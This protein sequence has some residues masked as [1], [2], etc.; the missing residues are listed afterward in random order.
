[1]TKPDAK[2]ICHCIESRI[3][4][5]T[6][7][8]ATEFASVSL[9]LQYVV[10]L[11][12]NNAKQWHA[13]DMARV[14]NITDA[15]VGQQKRIIDKLN[16]RRVDLINR[17]HSAFSELLLPPGVADVPVAFTSP[18][19]LID[20]LSILYLRSH[21]LRRALS[22]GSD[23]A[24]LLNSVNECMANIG[25]EQQHLEWLLASL[26]SGSLKLFHRHIAK[27]YQGD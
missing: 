4:A 15:Q 21:M 7:G 27:V 22:K 12:D 25:H 18:A 14:P 11:T 24:G 17:L 5:M 9:I 1:M 19:D 3:E 8:S 16:Q 6:I 23:A 20:R 10:E 13:E 2:T 26:Y